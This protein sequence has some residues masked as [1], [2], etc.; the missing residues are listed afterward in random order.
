M[1]VVPLN[2]KEEAVLEL[3]KQNYCL[4]EENA[5]LKRRLKELTSSFEDDGVDHSTYY[6]DTERNK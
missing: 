4:K 2:E 3:L 5:L 6:Y 1:T